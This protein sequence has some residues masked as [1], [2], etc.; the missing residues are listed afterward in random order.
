ME[1]CIGMERKRLKIIEVSGGIGNQMFQYALYKKLKIC[2][3]TALLDDI[4]VIHKGN[5]H[6]GLELTSAF[7]LNYDRAGKVY[8][9]RYWLWRLHDKVLKKYARQEVYPYIL[10]DKEPTAFTDIINIRYKYLRGY[11]QN[12]EFFRDIRD[13]IV[14]DFLF[15]IENMN[16]INSVLMHEIMSCNAVSVHIRRG[17]YLWEDNV[18]VRGNI[19]T[20]N[21]YKRAFEYIKSIQQNCR[22]YFFTDDPE[23]VRQQFTEMDYKLIDWNQNDKSYLDMYFMT[24]C[25]HNI[26]A[27]SSFSWWGAWLNRH[28]EKIVICPAKWYNGRNSNL[29]LDSWVKISADGEL[30]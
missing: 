20:T 28:P 22:F 6:N 2:G 13:T 9:L 29:V 4:E 30:I 15:N 25:K 19:C 14:E 12:E 8:R 3:F 27:N 10:Y 11:W 5:Q 1:F 26:I 7:A 21:Y 17:D 16:Q 23:W 18:S 24:Q